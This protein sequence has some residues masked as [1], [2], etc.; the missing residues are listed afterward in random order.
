M[1]D[2]N[3]L[4]RILKGPFVA[5]AERRSDE[6]WWFCTISTPKIAHKGHRTA[7]IT[8][9][10]QLSTAF[11]LS[12]V[13]KPKHCHILLQTSYKLAKIK[14]HL[15]HGKL[16][17]EKSNCENYVGRYRRDRLANGVAYLL[18]QSEKHNCKTV[19]KRSEKF[20][21]ADEGI[22]G[23]QEFSLSSAFAR[24]EKNL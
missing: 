10:T 5:D 18:I 6:K 23:M 1:E 20:V 16:W 11:L 22:F 19:L 3:K 24:H 7:I 9:C 4:R 13:R 21:L 12:F 15:K 2:L 14:S 8:S 17:A